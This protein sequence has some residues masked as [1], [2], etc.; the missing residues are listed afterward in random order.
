MNS[1]IPD[2]R[3]TEA[4]T[5]GYELYKHNWEKIK[6]ALTNLDPTFA[7]FVIEIPYGSVYPRKG[8]SLKEK[9]LVAITSLTCLGLKPQLKS[10]LI[11]ALNQGYGYDQLAELF[12]HLAM[13]IGFPLAMDG[14]KVLKEIRD[15]KTK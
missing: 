2:N 11:A 9:E 8:L 13:F 3:E 6:S 1:P 14:L 12:L 15:E 5:I 7:K 4:D 10:H